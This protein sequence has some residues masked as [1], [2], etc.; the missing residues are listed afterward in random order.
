MKNDLRSS[1]LILG[2]ARSGKSSYAEARAEQLAQL[3]TSM[4]QDKSLIYI[5]TATAQDHEM[6]QR[7][8]HHQK[9]RSRYW[10]VIEEQ[11]ALAN[12]LE[13]ITQPSIV[14]IDCLTLWLNNCLHQSPAVW[15]KEKN[16]LLNYIPDS[17]HDLIF[18][19]NEVGHGIVPLG[20]LSR[21]FVDESGWLHQSLASVCTEVTMVIAGL[22]QPLK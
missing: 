19:S 18:V 4:N 5:A 10:N 8:E 20:E 9:S 14:L 6:K 22:P 7:I 1:H 13:E 21:T 12:R 16:E 15:E 17:K 11:I 3:D 2:G